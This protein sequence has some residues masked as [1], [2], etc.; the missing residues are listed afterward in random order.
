MI[1]RFSVFSIFVFCLF[2]IIACVTVNI[3]FPAGEVQKAADK[4][5]EE[6]RP[7]PKKG[8]GSSLEPLH[9]PWLARLASLTRSGVAFAEVNIDISTPAIRSLRESIAGR[10]DSLKDYYRR[11]TLG[12]DN[13]GYVEI[14]DQ[15]GL[16]LKQKADLRRLADAENRDRDAL[17]KEII[18]ANKM[19]PRFKTEVEKIFSK[20]WRSKAIPGSW[21]QNDDGTWVRK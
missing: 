10:F 11:G 12:E 13:R 6:A 3:Y 2:L 5:V 20:S 7:E 17:Y 8:G 21:I 19:D 1:K 14:R 18:K 4:I 9:L 16:D 15:S